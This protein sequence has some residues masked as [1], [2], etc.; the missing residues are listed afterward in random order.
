[1]AEQ[2]GHGPG[3]EPALLLVEMGRDE[4]EEEAQMLLVQLH[5]AKLHQ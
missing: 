1:V 2:S 4:P 5:A 3:N